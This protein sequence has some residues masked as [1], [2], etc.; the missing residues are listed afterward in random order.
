MKGLVPAIVAFAGVTAL[1]L[2]GGAVYADSPATESVT[3][4]PPPASGIEDAP[5]IG[6]NSVVTIAGFQSDLWAEIETSAP[7]FQPAPGGNGSKPVTLTAHSP[8]P[9]L[10]ITHPTSGQ[11]GDPSAQCTGA[12]SNGPVT[13]TYTD[14]P[15]TPGPGSN[16]K[17]DM[18]WI[19]VSA[20]AKPGVIPVC[21]WGTADGHTAGLQCYQIHVIS[22]PTPTPTPTSTPTPPTS[23]PTPTPTS[24]GSG[25]GTST[26]PGLPDTGHP[27]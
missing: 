10:T 19:K 3:I 7:N 6:T 16:V 2:S 23:T 15:T 1:L 4:A 22:L 5:G 24:G 12:A 20:D 9:Y 17:R 8:S 18:F 14:A 13:C 26:G 21:V 11:Q 25:S 27:A